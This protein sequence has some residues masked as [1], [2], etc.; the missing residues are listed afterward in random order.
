MP[1]AAAVLSSDVFPAWI[2]AVPRLWALCFGLLGLVPAPTALGSMYLQEAFDYPAATQLGANS[3]WSN[4]NASIT[5]ASGS[6]SLG[7]FTD[8]SPAGNKVNMAASSGSTNVYRP[9]DAL[10]SGG[11]VYCS[12]LASAIA[13]PGTSGYVIGGM[14]TNAFAAA[15]SRSSDPV[16]LNAKGTT[17]G[18]TLGIAAGGDSSARYATNLLAAGSTY[19]IVLKFEFSTRTASLFINPTPGGAEPAATASSVAGASFTF[20]NLQHFYFRGVGGSGT[21]NFDTLRIASTWA[22]V[23][24]SP[25][26]VSADNST[27]TVNPSA[28]AADG[29]ASTTITITAK[30]NANS[31]LPGIP[32]G[33]ITVAAS[34]TG[35]VLTQP[36][37]A[38][39][40]NGQT[41]AVLK[42]T[43]AEVKT[44]SVT[45]IGTAL[46]NRPTVT[47]TN[48]PLNQPPTIA[49]DGQPQSRS[50]MVGAT[51]D[52]SVTAGG[53]GTLAYQWRKAAAPLFEQTHATLTFTNVAPSDQGSY[54]VVITNDYGSVT[55]AV[56]VLTVSLPPVALPAS[57]WA[58]IRSG[59]NFD[60]DIDEM[61]AGYVLTKYSANID[62]ATGS[63]GAAKSYLQF[64]FTGQAPDTHSPI[65][66]NFARASNSGAQ[67]VTVWALNQPFP[68]MS[69]NLTW[70]T[71]QANDTTSNGMLTNGPLTATALTNLVVPGGSGSAT[72]TLR[73]PWEQ[74]VQGNKLLLALTANDDAANSANGL[75]IL[76]TNSAQVLSVT[77]AA[78]QEQPPSISAGGQPQDQNVETGATPSFSVAALG[79]LPL[80]Y[81]WYVNASTPHPAGTNA[82]LTLPSVSTNNAGSYSVVVSNAY[83][84]CT[85][86]FAVLTINPPAAP[87]VVN[88]PASQSVIEGAA[89]SF[90]VTASGSLPFGYQWY[91]NQ[92]NVLDNATNSTLTLSSTTTNDA[93]AYDVVVT[94]GYGWARSAVGQLIVKLNT[95][96]PGIDS[97]PASQTVP[98]GASVSLS[99]LASGATPLSYQWFFN[100]TNALA[101]GTNAT[102]VLRSVAVTNGGPYAVVVSNAYGSRTSA[103]AMLTVSTNALPVN[104]DDFINPRFASVGVTS[105]IKFSDVLNYKGVLTSLYLDVYQPTGDTATNRPVILWIHG[106]GLR[107]GSS[108]AQGY[109][110]TYATDFAKRGYVCI[111]IDYRLRAGSDMPTTEAEL[112]ALQD[113]ASDANVALAWIRSHAREYGINPNWMFVAGGSAGGMVGCCVCYVDGTNAPS[114]PGLVFDQSG[115]IA[116]GDLWGSPEEP[117]RWYAQSP[118]A[119]NSYDTPTCI[120]HGTADTTVPFQN[121][122]DLSNQLAAAGVT[123]ELHPLAGYGHT[124]TGSSTDPLIESWLA[125]F[126]AEQWTKALTAPP[127]PPH[128]GLPTVLADGTVQLAFTSAPGA[129]FTTLGTTNPSWAV[130]NWNVLGSTTEV[131]PGQYQFTDLQATNTPRRFYLLRQP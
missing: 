87:S 86:S 75:R 77:F 22:E 14:L 105:G 29:I 33:A 89:V 34:G 121:S 35:N 131:A 52:F 81:Q 30:D 113:A 53:S 91:F 2:R 28:L 116:L 63:T 99:V 111:S 110:V 43:T 61:T 26:Q 7:G 96:P 17:G 85:S 109:I 27:L 93:G 31:P 21:W 80:S 103:V 59:V 16:V 72:V 46:T 66:F 55:S 119:L 100:V 107:T 54:D 49:S 50:V 39:D 92:T 42:S 118:H 129:R 8:L 60:T 67:N 13:A 12:F 120:V 3:P 128:L 90:S 40:S 45:L 74:F 126:F 123:V 112:P 98:P 69:N 56:A 1:K 83:G 20:P 47:F 15:G 84:T 23:T 79:S 117:K 108:R 18:Y 32:A 4:V 24:P 115:I 71:A 19:L 102:L 82:V 122:L 44:I 37:A 57:S 76:A 104:P 88:D 10:A 41:W 125:N 64:D 124:P 36:A 48:P 101:D 73:A 65:A 95:A 58:T 5:L 94:N 130:S 68:G 25:V 38:T 70:A 114:V 78:V 6:L 11:T 106:G 97:Q 9:F 51:V 62:P 127:A